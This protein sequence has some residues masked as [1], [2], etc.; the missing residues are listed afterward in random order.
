[1]HPL[2]GE[3]RLLGVVA[4]IVVDIACTQLPT[5]ARTGIRLRGT[6]PLTPQAAAPARR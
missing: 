2:F 4:S 1:V 3:H 6:R 5:F